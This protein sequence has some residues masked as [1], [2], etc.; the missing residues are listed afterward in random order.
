MWLINLLR[1]ESVAQATMVLGLVVGAGLGLGSLRVFK[2]GLGIA[3]VLFAGL[4]AGHLLA[5][6]DIHISPPMLDFA[7]EFGLTLF[8]YT[9]GIQVGPGFFASLRRQGLP[10]NLMAASVVFLGAG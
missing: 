2:T 8:V 6:N 1:V 9:I 10:L 3:G 7:R 4:L 5:R